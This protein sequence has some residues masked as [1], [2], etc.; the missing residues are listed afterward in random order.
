MT[1]RAP[2]GDPLTPASAAPAA[3]DPALAAA[4]LAW[5]SRLS[6]AGVACR[7]AAFHSADPR[8]TCDFPADRPVLRSAWAALH[9]RVSADSP[10]ALAKVDGSAAS[11]LLMAT[12]L[13]LPTG[14]AGTVGVALAPPHNERTVQLVLLSL[15]WLQLSLAAASLA[16]NQRSAR[17]LELMG[18]V[19]AQTEARAGAQEWV[20]RTA[21]WAR[22]DLPVS[23]AGFTLTLFELRHQLPRWW[24]GADTAWAEVASPAVQEATEVAARA[25]VECRELLQQPWWALPLLDDGEPVA[26]LVARYDA[27]GGAPLPA[28]TLA[29]LRASAGLAEP[30]L[31][32]WR[33]AGR[34]LL[35]HAVDS[36]R[37]SWAK[38]WGPG[39]L[40]WKVSGL[41]LLA[42]LAGLLLWPVPDRV[43]AHTVIEGS[44]RQVLTAPFEG[45]LAQVLVRP[46]ERVVKGQLMA[47]LDDRDLVLEQ[48]R[49]RSERDQ[50]AG[51]LRQARAERDAP[52]MALAQ[53]ELLQA[54]AQLAQVDAKLARAAVLATMDGLVVTGDWA[55]QVGA[56]VENG[57]ELFEIA[58]TDGYRVVLQV[59]DRDIARVRIGQVGELRL[60]GQ[61]QTGFAFRIS[62]VTATASVQDG[63]NGFRVEAA[64]QGPAPS[65]SPGLQGVGKIEVGRANLL[66]VWTRPSVDWLRLK[67]WG[68]WW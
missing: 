20:N 23:D 52:A 11:D 65:L 10:V 38:L 44:T 28:A 57:K 33:D 63:A 36:G 37:T 6:A 62:R 60:T 53:A 15:G 64:W 14:M 16:H 5:R 26:V 3:A 1:A 12:T 39:H 67:L 56:P 42:L 48:A 34:G 29:V 22:S 9:G 47:R 31:R 59:P 7:D 17:L 24:V 51:K 21:A 58:A 55:Q 35:P 25:A 4:L 49:H 66:T 54:E 8:W 27:A 30:L 45:F 2:S 13:Q 68:W 61:P 40:T 19:G 41:G 50:A 18:H 32:H 43:T 46:G